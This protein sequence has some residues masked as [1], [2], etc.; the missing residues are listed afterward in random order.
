MNLLET[1]KAQNI[2]SYL[3]NKKNIIFVSRKQNNESRIQYLHY[4]T[5]TIDVD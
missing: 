2:D 1:Q 4:Y 5:Q 3:Q